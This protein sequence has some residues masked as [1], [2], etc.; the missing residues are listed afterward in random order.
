MWIIIPKSNLQL[1]MKLFFRKEGTG[2]PLII[3]HGMYGSS[4]NWVAIA[5]RLSGKY[6]VY[7]PDQR[8]HGHS[9]HVADHSFEALKNDLVEF[10]DSNQIEKATVL[11]HSMGGKVAMMFAA[12]YP[13]KIN[14][15]IVADIAPVDYML[16]MES[17]QFYLH[18]N[19]LTALLE[20]NLEKVHSREEVADF[21]AERIGEERIRQFL[22]KNLARDPGTHRFFWR[23]NAEALYNYLEEIVSGVNRQWYD[24]RLPI[25]TYPVLF[26][27]GGNS[28]YIL[29][30]DEKTIHEIYPEAR[31]VTISNAGHWLHAEQ[32]DLFAKAVS[33]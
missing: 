3:L 27:K 22:M 19:I 5:R 30:D 16:R 13:E 29:P 23:L 4:D 33:G 6:S 18:R 14:R 2:E 32:P 1:K 17:S 11:G 21:L 25:T 10:M 24:A 9:P 7:L 28:R 31:I 8:N 12:D 20:I 15:L 26:I